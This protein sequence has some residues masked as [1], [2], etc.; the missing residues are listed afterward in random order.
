VN[1]VLQWRSVSPEQTLA[2]GR[3]LGRLLRA[4]ELVAL[5]GALGSGKTQ[6]VKGIA[7]GLGV[8]PDEPVVSPT[9]MLV[10]EY[11]G[12]L[13]L[14]HI[15]AYRL[16]RA[17]ELVALGLD[18]MLEDAGGVVAVEWADRVAEVL[19]ASAWWIEMSHV[20]EQVRGL[21]IRAPDA[22]RL[23]SLAGELG[24]LAKE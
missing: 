10:R 21:S 5:C 19:P 3:A 24:S 7:D 1:H 20:G 6:L 16:G 12:R 14:Y 22:V 18:E 8:P 17:D 13:K 23:E 15:D 11:A 4:G 9:F 2:I